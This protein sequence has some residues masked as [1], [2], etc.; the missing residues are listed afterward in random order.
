MNED[1]RQ[2][3]RLLTPRYGEGEA[4]AIAF[5]VMEELAGLTRTDIYAGKDSQF[6]EDGR[7][8]FVNTCE[9]LANGEPVQY[10]LG[11]A[12]FLSRRFRVNSEVLIPRPETEELVEWAISEA[13]AMHG[14]EP[15]RIL[16]AGT[17]SGCIAIS[18]QLA[19]PGFE[20]EAW[21]ISYGALL[22][23]MINILNLEA[24]VSLK[25]RDM[26]APWPKGEMFDLIVSN[27]PYICQSEE[28]G[29]E[30]NVLDYEPHLA[31]FVPDTDP[32]RFYRALAR[33]AMLPLRPGG[34]LM[35]EANRAYATAT[36]DL[37]RMVGLHDVELRNDAFGNPRMVRGVR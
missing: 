9:R 1:F 21:D 19:L 23:C 31:L 6:S 17:G 12:T 2:L 18:L 5:L 3:C 8:R 4:R 25:K 36:A 30:R 28:A 26:L 33:E 10:V 11:H 35:V 32:L 27:P 13:R 22:N 34:R 29:M 24:H 7:K 20:V 14:K 16:D 37:I 15:L